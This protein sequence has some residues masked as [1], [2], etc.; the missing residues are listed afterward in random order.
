MSNPPPSK[1]SSGGSFNEDIGKL[2]L[3]LTVGGLMLFHG[4]YKV[5]NGVG[6]IGDLL[7]KKGLPEFLAYG[8]YVGEVLAPLLLI[9]GLFT[10][11]AGLV[12]SFTMA[13]AI[14]LAH[15]KDIT[16]LA[17]QGGGWAVELPMFYLLCGVVIFLFG[18]G[19]F[20]V[21]RGKGPLN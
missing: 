19:R 14:F 20:G 15:M 3:R 2:V 8:V 9:L 6:G 16:K 4:F 21:T 11:A 13:T 1:P 12:V 7:D 18:C 5:Q 10:R 17:D